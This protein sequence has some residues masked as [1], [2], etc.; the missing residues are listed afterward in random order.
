MILEVVGVTVL[1]LIVGLTV[2]KLFYGIQEQLWYPNEDSFVDPNLSDARVKFASLNEPDTLYLSIIIPAYNEKQR[3]PIM[4]DETLSYLKQRKAKDSNFTY[5]LIVVDDGSKDT[6]SQISLK[7]SRFESTKVIRVLTLSKNR[8]KGGAV[9]RGMMVARGKYLLMADADAATKIQDLEKLEKELHSVEKNGLGIALGSRRHLQK[10]AE[11]KR[12][13]YR[14]ILMWGFHILV[15]LLCVKGI[16]DTQCGFKLFTRRT[17]QILFPN[18]HVERWAFDVELLYLA[19]RK[20]VPLVEVDVQWTEVPGSTLT[21]FAA[22]VQM[23][24]D[25]LRIRSAYFFG[26]WT[27]QNEEK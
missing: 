25:L 6:T 17:A 22:S 27:L 26:I 12:K 16:S 1:G 20:S 2:L 14:N 3:L 7:Y 9:K 4:L 13:W 15:D 10:L 8:G 18:Q 5:E 19:Q 11:K 23:G 21:P 24:K